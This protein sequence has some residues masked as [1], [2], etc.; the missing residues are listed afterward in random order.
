[1]TTCPHAYPFGEAAELEFD[2]AYATIRAE[3]PLARIRMPYGAD[4][5]LATRYEDVRT[6]LADPRFSRAATVGADVPRSVPERNERPETITNI[7]PPE[8][9]RLRRLVAAAF[10]ARRV[11]GMREH[12]QRIA[13]G[14]VDDLV[15]G[16]RPAE[17]TTA[18]S[19]P[20]PVVVICEMLGVPLDGRDTFRAAADAALSTSAIPAHER[21]AAFET[22]TSYIASLVAERR[23]RP[24][25]PGDDLLGGLISARDDDGDRLSEKEL[26]SLGVAILIAGHE[27]TMN[28]TG[29]MV[30]QLLTDRSRWEWLVED[31]DRI[32]GAVEEMLRFIPL[33]RHGGLPRVAT[34]DVEL[35][36]RTVRAGEAVLVST[37]AAN[38][39]PEV[40]D[41]PEEMRL[42]R[43]SGSHIAFGHGPHF[44]LG[45][46][47]AR[48][49]LQTVLRT[50][51]T[52]LP[53]LDLAGE[54][55]WRTTALVRGPASLPVTW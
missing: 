39:D 35:S 53:G 51:V 21:Q 15:A 52:R 28:M 40:F 55:E 42:D 16:G 6:V 7:D 34:E 25:G 8:H 33:G 22:L 17:L 30:I 4:G 11:E 36:G 45:A 10:T 23:E 19:M 26:V 37:I 13:D 24:D 1:M 43:A 9:G 20:L 54:I 46:S 12:V 31:P 18:V 38:R 44:C 29:D 5:W 3:E 48:M 41:D 14:L 2:P 32:R 27:T 50:L 49:E 47:L